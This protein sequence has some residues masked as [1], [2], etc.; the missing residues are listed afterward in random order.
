MSSGVLV[1]FCE[2]FCLFMMFY[3]SYVIHVYLC[4]FECL[5]SILPLSYSFVDVSEYRELL[6]SDI[7]KRVLRFLLLDL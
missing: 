6:S 1:K 4:F 5:H 7:H 2:E 3:K